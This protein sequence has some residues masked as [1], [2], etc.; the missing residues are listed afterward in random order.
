MSRQP[1]PPA[2]SPIP[3]ASNSRPSPAPLATATPKKPTADQIRKRAYE[4]YLARRGVG[5]SPEQDWIKAEREL[6]QEMNGR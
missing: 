3:P 6:S 1:S 5:G 2:K 4:L